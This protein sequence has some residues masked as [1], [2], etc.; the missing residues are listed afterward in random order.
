[1][2]V[3]RCFFLGSFPFSDTELRI[4]IIIII[5]HILYIY[6]LLL[7]SQEIQP[8]LS[9]CEE[10]PCTLPVLLYLNGLAPY[11]MTCK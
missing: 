2:S 11:S 6:L 9:F 7:R 10:G 5:V 1:M 8:I 3:S 4:M